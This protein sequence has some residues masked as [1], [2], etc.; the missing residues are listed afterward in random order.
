MTTNGD[1]A[2]ALADLL[3]A[4][5]AVSAYLR[6][7]TEGDGERLEADDAQRRDAAIVRFRE[8]VKGAGGDFSD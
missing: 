8:A 6:L 3:D 7:S 4:C 1:L 5:E 2:D